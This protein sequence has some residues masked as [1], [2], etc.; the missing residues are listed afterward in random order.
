MPCFE[1]AATVQACRQL[2]DHKSL[3]SCKGHSYQQA[4]PAQVGIQHGLGDN[5]KWVCGLRSLLKRSPCIVY[6][7]GSNGETSFEQDILRATKCARLPANTCTAPAHEAQRVLL[8]E[9]VLQCSADTLT[10]CISGSAR[11]QCCLSFL[12][13]C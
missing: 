5:G 2:A 7:F 13:G 12:A 10:S 9:V 1:H 3:L 4:H 6:S 8:Q 11:M